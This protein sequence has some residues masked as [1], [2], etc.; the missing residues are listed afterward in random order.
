MTSSTKKTSTPNH[1]GDG[2]KE[3]PSNMPDMS[4]YTTDQQSTSVYST[5]DAVSLFNMRTKL[6]LA[7]REGFHSCF[8]RESA[9][10]MYQAIGATLVPLNRYRGQL[11]VTDASNSGSGIRVPTKDSDEY[12]LAVEMPLEVFEMTQAESKARNKQ[13]M[14]S[15]NRS[16]SGKDA[17]GAQIDTTVKIS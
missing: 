10:P 17:N 9:W 16:V 5:A 11:K 7:P 14:D 15:I 6:R 2:L 1:P 13:M 12:L 8:I 4:L 3:N